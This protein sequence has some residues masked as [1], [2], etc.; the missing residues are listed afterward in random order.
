MS[1]HGFGRGFLRARVKGVLRLLC[2]LP[3]ER[4]QSPSRGDQLKLAVSKQQHGDEHSWRHIER[5]CERVAYLGACQIPITLDLSLG[6]GYVTAA[7]K[8][9]LFSFVATRLLARPSI[10]RLF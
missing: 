1:P 9:P 2:V 6:R 3:P 4:Y 7:H 10:P 5:L 8:T